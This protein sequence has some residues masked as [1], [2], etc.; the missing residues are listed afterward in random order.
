MDSWGAE[1]LKSMEGSSKN[2]ILEFATGATGAS[3]SRH[4]GAG[5]AAQ[6]LPTTRARIQ[7]DG[8]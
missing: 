6:S 7:D 2:E 1:V 3:G 8:R 5:P 4:F